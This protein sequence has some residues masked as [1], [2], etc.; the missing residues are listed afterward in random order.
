MGKHQ[1]CGA[2]ARSTGQPCKRKGL[3]RGGKCRNHGGMSTGP[4]TPEGKA[5]MAASVRARWAR[6]RAE[7]ATLKNSSESPADDQVAALWSQLT[8]SEEGKVEARVA[9]PEVSRICETS[10]GDIT[11]TPATFANGATI[12]FKQAVSRW[13]VQDWR[14]KVAGFR[15]SLDAAVE[16]ARSL[17]AKPPEQPPVAP[18]RAAEFHLPQDSAPAYRRPVVL[19]RPR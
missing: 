14:G 3:G 19:L 7:R 15:G 17:P 8:Q 13:F 16:L 9:E 6:Y 11:G 4:R 18:P 10:H 1:F 12:G 2:Y 5:S